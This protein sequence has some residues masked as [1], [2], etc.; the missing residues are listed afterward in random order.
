[1]TTDVVSVLTAYALVSVGALAVFLHLNVWLLLFLC[2]TGNLKAAE[3][4]A[5]GLTEKL[6]PSLIRWQ[7]DS[8]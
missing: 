3:Y 6:F 1:M 8:G 5:C 7:G 2:Y 4:A